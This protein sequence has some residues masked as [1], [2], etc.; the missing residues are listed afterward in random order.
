ME[1]IIIAELPESAIVVRTGRLGKVVNRTQHGT[2]GV[3]VEMAFEGQA[4]TECYWESEL[5]LI[6]P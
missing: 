6:I 4:W 3:M 2:I 1:Y 5:T